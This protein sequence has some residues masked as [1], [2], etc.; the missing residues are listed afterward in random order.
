MLWF[1]GLTNLFIGLSLLYVTANAMIYEQIS[2]IQAV[3][4]VFAELGLLILAITATWISTSETR[5]Q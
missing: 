4:D 1:S 3:R 5:E 2:A